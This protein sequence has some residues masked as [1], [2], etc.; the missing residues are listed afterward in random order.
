[1]RLVEQI[2]NRLVTIAEMYP[3]HD[4]VTMA[5]TR[6]VA[7]LFIRVVITEKQTRSYSRD[8]LSV[9]S[10]ERRIAWFHQ[11]RKVRVHELV[12]NFIG[13]SSEILILELSL[14]IRSLSFPQ[15]KV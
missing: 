2:F 10:Y 13:F 6:Y 14:L 12:N 9:A 8:T 1:M 3:R 11:V 15:L 5:Q 4:I 7:R